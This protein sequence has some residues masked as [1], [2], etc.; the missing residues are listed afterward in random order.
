M[1][2]KR[3][4]SEEEQALVAAPTGSCCGSAHLILDMR[5]TFHDNVCDVV[6]TYFIETHSGYHGGGSWDARINPDK[7]G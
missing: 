6:A 3:C 4:Q 1:V 7:P 5:L 2:L